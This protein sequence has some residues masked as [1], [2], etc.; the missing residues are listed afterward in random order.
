LKRSARRDATL[1]RETAK[2]QSPPSNLN[3]ERRL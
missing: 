3:A 1:R 2:A